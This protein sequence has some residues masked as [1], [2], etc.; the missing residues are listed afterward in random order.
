MNRSRRPQ[1][2]PAATGWRTTDSPTRASATE[3]T[4]TRRGGPP[5]NGREG[6]LARAGPPT[7][8]QRG[9]AHH[10]DDRNAVVEQR[11][12]GRPHRHAADEVL[13]A[14]DRVDHPLPAREN[15]CAAELFAEHR[16]RRAAAAT[17]RR[18]TRCPPTR[19]AS[20]AGVRSGLVS[21]RRSSAPNRSIVST[22]AWSANR[23][24]KARSSPDGAHGCSPTMSV[25]WKS[26]WCWCCSGRWR[27]RRTMDQATSRRRQRLG[28]GPPAGHRGEPATRRHR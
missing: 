9:R 6:A 12:Q 28:A 10:T 14:V 15:R 26:P 3:D 13:G 18:A 22:S 21:T 20:V 19:S 23:S 5:P 8:L 2:R 25:C 7:A 1:L 17:G 11:D 27:S 24:A 16:G 4:D